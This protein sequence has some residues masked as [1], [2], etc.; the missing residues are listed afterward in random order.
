MS[1][2]PA[3]LPDAPTLD[4]WPPVAHVIRREDHPPKEG[5]RAL[6]GKKLMGV[7]L[8]GMRNVTVCKRCA[9]I[10]RRMSE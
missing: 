1:T 3:T 6:C 5:T 2:E 10:A 7:D 8:D 9:E 4:Q